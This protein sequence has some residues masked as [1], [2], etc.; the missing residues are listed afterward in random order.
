MDREVKAGVSR[1]VLVQKLAVAAGG[2]AIFVAVTNEAAFAKAS[3]KAVAY[4]DGPKGDQRCD[5]CGQFQP[6]T[7]CKVV[8]GDV[9]PAG[10][11]KVYVKKH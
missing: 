7:S 2:A 3:Q 8:D 11:C 1:R 10:W 4:Q 5:N 9:S 6:P